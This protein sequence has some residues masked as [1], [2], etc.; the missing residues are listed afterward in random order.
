[1]INEF[2][3]E[4]LK[5]TPQVQEVIKIYEQHGLP[6]RSI[7]LK[8]GNNTD[9]RYSCL[10]E[11]L[12]GRKTMKLYKLASGKYKLVMLEL[13]YYFDDLKIAKS[14]YIL[15]V[16]VLYLYPRGK[17]QDN[18]IDKLKTLIQIDESLGFIQKDKNE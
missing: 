14:Y 18:L 16:E 12:K 1:M 13:S 3:E 6:Q 15:F 4:V 9:N 2:F 17:I 11:Y 10:R 8:M 7:D 5:S